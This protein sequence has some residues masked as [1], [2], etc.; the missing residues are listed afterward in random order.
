MELKKV[1]KQV[2]VVMGIAVVTIFLVNFLST[3]SIPLLSPLAAKIK[4]G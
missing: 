4:A 3:K 2:G 1:G